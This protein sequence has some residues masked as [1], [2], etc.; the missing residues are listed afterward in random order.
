MGLAAVR[1]QHAE[2]LTLV[3]TPCVRHALDT[4]WADIMIQRSQGTAILN[5]LRCEDLDARCPDMLPVVLE[6]ESSISPARDPGLAVFASF[7][8]GDAPQSSSAS[9]DL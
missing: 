4:Y 1:I 3:F 2:S 6:V 9:R 5:A 7:R 8:S